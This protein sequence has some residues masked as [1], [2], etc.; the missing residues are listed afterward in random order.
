MAASLLKIICIGL[1]TAAL[2]TVTYL[3]PAAGLALEE[4]LGLELLFHLRGE[5]PAPPEVV[6]VTIDQAAAKALGLETDPGQWPRV[7]HARLV[8]ALTEAGAA[9]IAFNIY[10]EDARNPA[11]DRALATSIRRAGNVILAAYL[12]HQ[13]LNT[14]NASTQ[15]SIERVAPPTPVLASAPVASV[16]FTLPAAAQ[17]R[18]FWTFR[19]AAGDFPSLPAAVLQLYA[20]DSYPAMLRLLDKFKL[21]YSSHL[22]DTAAEA[23]TEFGL[24]ELMIALRTLFVTQ[25]SLAPAVLD[26][27]RQARSKIRDSEDR[28][29]IEA[30][31]RMYRDEAEKYLNFYGPPRSIVTLPYDAVLREDGRARLDLEG[32]AV[33]I[34]FSGLLSREPEGNFRTVFTRA[35]GAATSSVEIAATAFANLLE[36]RVLTEPEPATFIAFATLHALMLAALCVLLPAQGAAA[37]IVLL[38]AIYIGSCGYFFAANSAWLPS[39]VPLLLQTPLAALSTLMWGQW[40]TGRERKRLHHVFGYYLPDNIVHQLARDSARAH[41]HPR[42]VFGICLVTDT[43]KAAHRPPRDATGAGPAN[44]Y[45]QV[46]CKP[47]LERGGVI[48]E[49][50]GDAMLALWS[51]PEPNADLK[52]RACDAALDI[53]RGVARFEETSGGPATRTRIGLHAGWLAPAKTGRDRHEEHAMSDILDAAAEIQR[54]NKRLGTRVLVSDACLAGLAGFVTR[55]V[56]AFRVAGGKQNINLHEVL[57]RADEADPAQV[58]LSADF[59]EALRAYQAQ[60]WDVA[61]ARFTDILRTFPGDGPS[62]LYLHMCSPHLKKRRRAQG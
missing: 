37:A 36:G 54:L 9:L 53:A 8:D 28:E 46:L 11:H 22:P 14:P 38:S 20:M 16:P 48:S 32:K 19:R 25:P 58:A 18:E 40:V 1:F 15:I 5:R 60:A 47:V 49:L 7:L 10:F 56:G 41:P 27:L 29:R 17:A 45:Y 6:V 2:G 26:E 13:I 59:A 33:F 24:V 61:A 55:G 4:S 3:V 42:S 39:A 62:L 43:E 12:E 30:V 23:L 52:T 21:E 35:D 51:G 44:A 31:V 57:C 50:I 34:G